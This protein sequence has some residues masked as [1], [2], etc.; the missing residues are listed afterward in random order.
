MY[1]FKNLHISTKQRHFS[2]LPGI[3]TLHK[4]FITVSNKAIG[5]P[6]IKI[7][8][9]RI[10]ICSPI[11]KSITGWQYFLAVGRAFDKIA[12]LVLITG[13]R[14]KAGTT[15]MHAQLFLHFGKVKFRLTGNR[16]APPDRR[17]S[18]WTVSCQ[19][20]FLQR[21]KMSMMMTRQHPQQWRRRH[22]NQQFSHNIKMQQQN[23]TNTTDVHEDEDDSWSSSEDLDIVLREETRNENWRYWSDSLTVAHRLTLSFLKR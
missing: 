19:N 20:P 8:T 22:N 1:Y 13:V 16:Y 2:K 7:A 9:Q 4:E 12:H 10:A 3:E 23:N 14:A 17:Y 5:C 6:G 18:T 11:S 21:E 15:Q